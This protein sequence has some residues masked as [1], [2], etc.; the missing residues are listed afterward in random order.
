MVVGPL[1]FVA[2]GAAGLQVIDVTDPTSPQALGF[3]DTPG[4]ARGVDATADGSLAVVADGALGI[5]VIDVSSRTAPQIVGSLDTGD[6]RDVAMGDGF[7]YVADFSGSLRA[8]DLA[9]PAS[10]A[11]SGST[12][13]SLGGRLH[14]VVLAGGFTFGADVLFVNGVP[15]VDV[16]APATPVARFILDFRAFRDDNGT[17]IAADG[18]HVYLTASRSIL[19]N[20]SSGTTRLYIG[21]YLSV[22]DVGGIPPTVGIT[23]PAPGDTVIEGTSLTISVDA[24]DDFIVQRVEFLVDG[25]VVATDTTAPYETT[26]VAPGGA[27]FVTLEARAVDS[28]GNVGTSSAV[29]IG[30]V[31]DPGTTVE[32]FVTLPDG[33]PA[34]GAEVSA[35][36]LSA[37]ADSLGFFSLAG[38]PTIAGAIVVNASLEVEG[39]R[40]FGSSA[41]LPPLPAGVVD[42]GTIVLSEARFEEELGN[43]LF[44][45]DDD[46]D[47]IVF[48]EGFSFPFFGSERSSIFVNSNGNLTFGGG[49]TTFDPAV[50][51][52]VVSGLA[53][54]S[55]LYTDLNPSAAFIPGSGVFV[56]QHPDR[57]VVTWNRVPQFGEGGDNTFQTVL[58]ADGRIQFGYNGLTADGFGNGFGSDTLDI[59]VAVSPGGSPTLRTADYSTEAPFSRIASEAI[60]ENFNIDGSFDLT[61]ASCSSRPTATAATTSASCRH[62]HPPASRS[63]AARWSTPPARR[64]RAAWWSPRAPPRAASNCRPSRT[65]RDPLRSPGCRWVD[66]SASRPT[67]APPASAPGGSGWSRQAP[68]TRCSSSRRRRRPRSRS[69]RAAALRA[70]AG[71]RLAGVCIAVA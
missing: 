11:V 68:S 53:R 34:A 16:R 4:D 65:P 19:E 26:I 60:L 35:F 23:S 49:D 51:S 32:G 3:V 2:D 48:S 61:A 21:Q 69:D 40:F 50:P 31:P 56:N 6:A 62:R 42:A 63:C 17:G 43:N 41:A 1:A 38:L 66:S 27:G 71:L 18:S 7:V 64:W 59:S 25:A 54:I 67:T 44:Q 52:G 58:F 39:E 30:I 70:P 15:I 46:S 5:R 37:T 57:L 36:G 33:A 10:P 9:D 8:V 47:L 22:D 12:P 20:G 55:P 28:A 24:Q 14:D 45:S 29:S 13:L